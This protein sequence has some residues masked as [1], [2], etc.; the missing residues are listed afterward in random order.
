[1]TTEDEARQLL[2]EVHVADM[3]RG[4]QKL[5]EQVQ[6]GSETLVMK[7][8]TLGTSRPD[9]LGRAEREVD[10][11][12]A[13]NVIP[14]KSTKIPIAPVGRDSKAYRR[15]GMAMTG[16][17][18]FSMGSGRRPDR[19]RGEAEVLSNALSAVA[20]ARGALCFPRHQSDYAATG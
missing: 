6:R 20:P 18:C 7:M 13:E 4:G 11:V 1:M 8:V 10:L 14:V 12:G 17:E 5:V 15:C 16:A 3:K 19:G 9:A 2:G